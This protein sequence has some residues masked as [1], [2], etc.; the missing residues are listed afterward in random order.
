MLVTFTNPPAIG[1]L[2]LSGTGGGSAVGGSIA[3]C[4]MGSITTYTFTNQQF[5]ANNTT[6]TITVQFPGSTSA[7]TFTNS[8]IPAVANCSTST[9]CA[10]IAI[11]VSNLICVNA[12]NDSDPSNDYYTEM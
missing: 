2:T 12:G 6:G 10:I 5:S 11:N 4:S 1:N 3:S 7:C 8:A 9:A